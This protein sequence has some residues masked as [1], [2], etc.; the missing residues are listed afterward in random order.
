MFGKCRKFDLLQRPNKFG[1][2]R[3][4]VASSLLFPDEEEAP[5]NGGTGMAPGYVQ[6]ERQ[7]GK[8]SFSRVPDS[9]VYRTIGRLHV[10]DALQDGID[11]VGL[12]GVIRRL[13]IDPQ[14]FEVTFANEVTVMQNG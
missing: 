12:I 13:Q 3:P 10:W 8:Y 6:I 5:V 9:S 11:F 14:N 4:R 7:C 1:T 2:Q